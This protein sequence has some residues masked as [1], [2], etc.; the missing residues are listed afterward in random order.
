M[1]RLRPASIAGCAILIAMMAPVGL[2]PAAAQNSG[3]AMTA[4]EIRACACQKLALDQQRDTVDTQ[5][6]L[7]DERQQ[8]LANLDAEIKRQAASL[9]AEDAVGQ[10][11]LQDLIQQQMALRNMIQ[12][13]IRP[14]YNKSL[15]NLR[16]SVDAYNATCTSRPRYMS[17]AEAAE[18]NLVC[19][20]Q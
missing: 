17:D 12:L 14:D 16:Q 11:V 10:Q 5:A 13:R 8:E 15:S 2:S 20:G 7:L 1:P 6:A 19:P 9:P 4:D 3:P 18:Q